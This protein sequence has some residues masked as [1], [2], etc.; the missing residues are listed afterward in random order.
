MPEFDWKPKVT[1]TSHVLHKDQQT[2]NVQNVFHIKLI[3]KNW[4]CAFF[5][6]F[7]FC[8]ACTVCWCRSKIDFPPF[9]TIGILENLLNHNKAIKIANRAQKKKA[10]MRS[11]FVQAIE[12]NWIDQHFRSIFQHR[13]S[14]E[15]KYVV[16]YY[17]P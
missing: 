2:T 4:L 6:Y 7:F 9:Y 3:L 16:A 8:V 10:Y 5:S 11:I 14:N 12:R 1:M 15:I 17:W 13:V